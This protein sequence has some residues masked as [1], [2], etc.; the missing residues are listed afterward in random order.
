MIEICAIP[1]EHAVTLLDVLNSCSNHSE[2]H[3]HDRI[4][5]H[6]ACWRVLRILD[7]SQPSITTQIPGPQEIQHQCALT[8]Q[9]LCLGFVSY[10]QA[11]LGSLK[12][13]FLDTSIQAVRLGGALLAEKEYSSSLSFVAHL[14]DLTCLG[15]GTRAPL[16]SFHI[17]SSLDVVPNSPSETLQT[18]AYDIS[19]F[20]EDV[21]DTW[22]PASFLLTKDVK[23]GLIAIGI[24]GGYIYSTNEPQVCH[25]AAEIGPDSLS[26]DTIDIDRRIVIDQPAEVNKDCPWST[27]EALCIRKTPGSFQSLGGY[28][29]FHT[30]ESTI[31]ISGGMFVNGHFNVTGKTHDGLTWK[32][33]QLSVYRK[34]N[35]TNLAHCLNSI[36][37]LQVSFCTNVARRVPMHQLLAELLPKIYL[38]D[39]KN[40]SA[41][42]RKLDEQYNVFEVLRENRLPELFQTMDE[43]CSELL[44]ESILNV[45]EILEP[46]GL[47]ISGNHIILAWPTADDNQ[48]CREISCRGDSSWIQLLR[49]TAKSVTFAYITMICLETTDHVCR[50]PEATAAWQDRLDHLETEVRPGSILRPGANYF[51]RQLDGPFVM[52]AQRSP[53][54]NAIRLSVPFLVTPVR[55]Q[56]RFMER[57]SKSARSELWEYRNVSDGREDIVHV[58]VGPRKPIEATKA[59]AIV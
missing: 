45:L 32:K 47:D 13:F 23:P 10:L 25:W 18:K 58:V 31:G 7:Q 59:I 41:L 46:T 9:F 53:R 22:G 57:Y 20:V 50:G 43:Q 24:L 33:Y 19:G 51:F 16:F 38:P 28:Q 6:E 56:L 5:I 49:D 30:Y 55:F 4:R 39:N 14:E 27:Q 29:Q 15:V 17:Y 48:R 1:F 12:L 37:G 11:H 54:H 44:K 40:N 52:N 42:W 35:G 34:N 21:I 2:L 8:M 3:R 36:W 26:R